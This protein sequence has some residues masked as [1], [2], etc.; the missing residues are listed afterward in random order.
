MEEPGRLQSRGRKESDTT[1]RLSFPFQR[2]TQCLAYSGCSKLFIR[3]AG[4]PEVGGAA[5]GP[6]QTAG[7]QGV[8]PGPRLSPCSTSPEPGA[9][10]AKVT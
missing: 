9:G 7:G 4:A 3:P 8:G 1:E 2:I 5:E 6:A 10:R